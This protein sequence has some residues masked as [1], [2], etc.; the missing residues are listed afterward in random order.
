MKGERIIVP[1]PS[2][3]YPQRRVALRVLDPEKYRSEENLEKA[4]QREE[5]IRMDQGTVTGAAGVCN[6]GSRE[7]AVVDWDAERVKTCA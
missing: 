5:S 3:D 2:Q 1:T 4:K 6:H 7:R